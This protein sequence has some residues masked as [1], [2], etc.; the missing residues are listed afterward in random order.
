MTVI[1][2]AIATV[3]MIILCRRIYI[4]HYGCITI[5]VLLTVKMITI[6]RRIDMP[7]QLLY[8]FIKRISAAMNSGVHG[9]L[10]TNSF[11]Y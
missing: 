2:K 5:K 4:S 9:G 10:G 7:L 8:C 3:K 1:I 6:R 11:R